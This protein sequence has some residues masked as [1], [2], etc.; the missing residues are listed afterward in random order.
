VEAVVAAAQIFEGSVTEWRPVAGF[1]YAVSDGGDVYSFASRR[2]LKPFPH[3]DG[4]LF[5]DLCNGKGKAR[6]RFVHALVLE[7]FVGPAGIGQQARHLD[8]RPS[9]NDVTNLR[10]GTAVEN[11]RDR[12]RHGTSNKGRRYRAILSE[13][14]V[15]TIKRRLLDGETC[16]QIAPDYPVG[17][18]A[19]HSIRR[20][21]NWTNIE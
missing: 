4:H 17:V 19:I 3:R 21:E 12:V 18:T 15:R 1:A 13:E 11:Q 9:N 6:R 8:G 5:V 20:G 10:W 7:T 16:A 14:Q 2:L